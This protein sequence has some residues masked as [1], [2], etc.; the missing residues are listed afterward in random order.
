MVLIYDRR[1]RAI[2]RGALCRGWLG[3]CVE[4]ALARILLIPRLGNFEAKRGFRRGSCQMRQER[5]GGSQRE[6]MSAFLAVRGMG[7][8]GPLGELSADEPCWACR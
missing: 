6:V 4:G 7:C 2:E 1:W 8:R 5:D 3:G